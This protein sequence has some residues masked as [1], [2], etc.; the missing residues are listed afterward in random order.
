MY[1]QIGCSVEKRM[2]LKFL[3]GRSG[4][5]QLPFTVCGMTSTEAGLDG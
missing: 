4:K 1:C 2:A 5:I 3:V